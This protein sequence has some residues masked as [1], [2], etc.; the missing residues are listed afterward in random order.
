M[1]LTRNELRK[2]GV[3]QPACANAE[4]TNQVIQTSLSQRDVRFCRYYPAVE[5][6]P[7]PMPI[8]QEARTRKKRAPR[9]QE[10]T[11]GCPKSLLRRSTPP[12]CV[13]FYTAE[14]QPQQAWNASTAD[15]LHQSDAPI[16]RSRTSESFKLSS[17]EDSVQRG[18]IGEQKNSTVC[19]K[20]D[21]QRDY[22]GCS[23]PRVRSRR[24]PIRP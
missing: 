7:V 15:H 20:Q 16:A 18:W 23:N 11:E 22:G 5:T 9:P 6:F 3:L 19:E 24:A 21:L 17:C 2:A 4:K 1:S 8:P 14:Q 13:Y 10:E 12:P